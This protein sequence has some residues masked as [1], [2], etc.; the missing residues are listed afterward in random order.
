ME[1]NT[2]A[3]PKS[4][5]LSEELE[6]LLVDRI[7]ARML[8]MNAGLRPSIAKLNEDIHEVH[9]LMQQRCKETKIAAERYT[10]GWA[11]PRTGLSYTVLVEDEVIK[12]VDRFN[13]DE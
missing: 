2:T 11:T 1:S 12:L 8:A 10:Y 6:D 7:A 5:S 3:S 13:T 4:K 9:K